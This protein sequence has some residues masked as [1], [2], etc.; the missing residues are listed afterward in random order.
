[1]YSISTTLSIPKSH[2]YMVIVL[3]NLNAE[4]NDSSLDEH[5]CLQEVITLLYW[6]EFEKAMY[7]EFQSLIENN[8]WEYQ[9][10]PSDRA[11]FISR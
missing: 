7:A 6:K 3:A 2:I 5:F 1:M 10:A 9:D 8:I 11:I 4:Y